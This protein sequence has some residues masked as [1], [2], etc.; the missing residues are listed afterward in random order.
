MRLAAIFAVLAAVLS[1]AIGWAV[2]GLVERSLERTE[3]EAL[4]SCLGNVDPEIERLGRG[5]AAILERVE[6]ELLAHDPRRLARVL[7]GGPD[8]VDEAKRLAATTDL[9]LLTILDEAE[10]VISSAHWPQLAGLV[11]PSLAGL[12]GQQR[13]LRRVESAGGTRL[14][15][16]VRRPV[17]VGERRLSLV[18]GRWLDRG[19]ATAVAQGHEAFVFDLE[20]G[21]ADA[22]ASRRASEANVALWWD[23]VRGDEAEGTASGNAPDGSSLAWLGGRR[24]LRDDDGRVRGAVVV[25]LPRDRELPARLRLAF[26]AV[27]VLAAALAA[28]AG[29]WAASRISRPIDRLVHAVDAIAAGEADYTF[30]ARAEH[31]LDRLAQ[32]FSR[33]Q[34]S[35]ELQRRRSAAA[36]RVAGWREVARRVAHEV[37]NPLVPIRL[38]V[39]NLKRAR[40]KDPHL[41][42]ELFDEGTRTILEEVEQLR[43]LVTEFSEFARLPAPRPQPVDLHGLLDGVLELHAAEPRLEIVR[44]YRAG[45]ATLDADAEQLGRALKNVV[46]NAVEA[47]REGERPPRLEVF[48]E[49]EGGMVEIRVCD[50]GPGI[51]PDAAGKVFEPYFTTK[52]QGTGLGMAIVYRIVTEHGGVVDADNRPDGGACIRIRLP[53]A[54]IIHE[55]SS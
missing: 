49:A 37:K 26:V 8:A 18:G 45:P 36:E 39:E 34:R 50:S 54:R 44:A 21:G 6:T 16:V 2:C 51:P 29:L 7:A 14:A 9:G 35:L 24:L 25:A 47:M 42:D 3:H 55:G 41:F 11:E 48:T 27:G 52:P 10:T 46:G 20:P 17:A 40:E 22:V 33:L 43:R 1:A 5:V 12:A 23:L 15:I 19:F 4:A 53:Q 31:E 13:V 32:A 28:L 38:T 30:P